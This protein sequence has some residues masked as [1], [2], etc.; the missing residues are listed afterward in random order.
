[1]WQ[2]DWESEISMGMEMLSMREVGLWGADKVP[3]R[4]E[5]IK[6]GT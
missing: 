2:L 5:E 1:M 6:K 4:R 3:M